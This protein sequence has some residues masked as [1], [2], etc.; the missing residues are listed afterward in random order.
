ML[1]IMYLYL[2][3][4]D[5]TAPHYF[6]LH[7]NNH[8]SSQVI[9]ISP[10]YGTIYNKCWLYFAC[11]YHEYKIMQLLNFASSANHVSQTTLGWAK[12]SAYSPIIV[13]GWPD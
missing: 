6:D 1:F 4:D 10:Q 2:H 13:V 3:E 9:N 12:F 11:F 7:V 5:H 8:S